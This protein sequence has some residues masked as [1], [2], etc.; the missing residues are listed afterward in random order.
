[1]K[2]GEGGVGGGERKGVGG[3]I[4]NGRWELLSDPTGNR[5]RQKRALEKNQRVQLMHFLAAF[6]DHYN[7]LVPRLLLKYQ[8]QGR[9]S[10]TRQNLWCCDPARWLAVFSLPQARVSHLLTPAALLSLLELGKAN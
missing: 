1:M 4:V 2:V 9:H 6:S 10:N 8:S 5:R 3:G 7:S